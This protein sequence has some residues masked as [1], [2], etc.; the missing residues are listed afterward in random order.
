MKTNLSS[1]VLVLGLG[2]GLF[3]QAPAPLAVPVESLLPASTYACIR[4][5]GLDACRAA[6]EQLPLATVVEQFLAK[7]PP[8]LRG[9]QVEKGLD[10]A[11]EFA[12]GALQEAG[13]NPAD[14]RAVLQ[15]PMVL[16]LGR[17]SVEGFGPSVALVVEAGDSQPA[18]DRVLAALEGQLRQ[19]AGQIAVDSAT[20]AGAT[21]RRLQIPDGPPV[22]LGSIGRHFVVSNSR[23]YLRDFV[24]VGLGK[25]PGL[26]KA[27]ALEL[28]AQ[29]LPQP[30]LAALFVNTR[31]LCGMVEAHLPYEA[32][33]FADALG[34]GAFD[35]L[36][37]GTTATARG[38]HDVLHLGVHGS[39]RGLFKA[40]TA[41]PASLAFAQRCAKSAVVFAAGSLDA[42]AVVE[43]AERLLALLPAAAQVE[44]ERDLVRE[45]ARGL[46]RLGS[47][48][49]HARQVMQALGNQVGIALQLEKGVPKP[50]LLVQVAVRDA[51]TIAPLLQQLEAMVVDRHGLEWKSRKVGDAEVRFVNVAL[52]AADL[53][54]SP[55]YALLPDALLFGSDVIALVRALKQGEKAED[56][57]AAQEDFAAMAQQCE[58]ASGVMHLRLFRAAE[59]GWRTVEQLAYPMLDGQR[60]EIG[61]GSDALPDAETLAQALGTSTFAYH[62]DDRGITLRSHGTFGF[63]GLLAAFGWLGDDV[64][65]RACGKVY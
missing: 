9:E 21:L 50:E 5:G 43:A 12:R 40:L 7:L 18:I 8:A 20:I 2:A 22:F 42:P 65:Q 4:F 37:A 48:P 26:G 28:A 38:G 51:S 30:A 10:E 39:E 62:V 59:L 57:L 3:A 14:V 29:Q 58:G 53:Q 31:S 64:L 44:V 33:D 63:G 52:P 47:N 36:F 25:Q 61:F 19:E 34:L 46:R 11:A 60:E 1:S 32:A 23:G 55:C 49:E 13:L 54:L 56:S 45:L 17:L 41:Q 6:A 16:A 27:S 24:E 15:R 35:G